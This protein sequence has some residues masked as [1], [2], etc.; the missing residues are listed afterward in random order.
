MTTTV[1]Q[2][3]STPH[4][5][6][7][8]RPTVIPMSRL[9]RVELRKLVDTRAG[10]WLLL[11]IAVVTV[12]AVAVYAFAADAS[13]LTF[14]HF[15]NVSVLPQSWLLPVL[16]IMAVT[17]EWTQRTGLVTH[18]LEPRRSRVLAA[19]FAATGV[20]GALA[21]VL[22]IAAAAVANL[23]ASALVDGN[24]SWSYGLGGLR[25]TVLFQAL[26]L[27]QG[28]ALAALLMNTAAAIVVYFVLPTA[29]GLL[30]SMVDSLT[31]VA[32]WIDISTSQAPLFDHSIDGVEW[33]QLLVTST[34][35][36]LVPLAA[37]LWRLLHREIK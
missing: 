6:P 13:E 7:A 11:G 35:W 1:E 16:G 8:G 31:G 26:S 28:L 23:L 5:R 9:V 24:G 29:F 18:T 15:V 17:S 10:R 34:G 20:L 27:L 12:A 33:L 21:I 25:D 19:K 2:A 14:Q 32:S 22:A 37:G 3:T 36:I 4:P 30:F